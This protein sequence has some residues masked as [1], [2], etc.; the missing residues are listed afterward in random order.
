MGDDDEAYPDVY[1]A[2]DYRPEDV[3]RA[4]IEWDEHASRRYSGELPRWHEL[5]KDEKR[6]LVNAHRDMRKMGRH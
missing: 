1:D 2:K 4:K 5:S 3:R 6:N